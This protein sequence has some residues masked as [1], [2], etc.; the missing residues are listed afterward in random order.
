MLLEKKTSGGNAPEKLG[1][2]LSFASTEAYNLLRANLT[3]SLPETGT[4]HVIG[5][6]SAIPQDGKTYTAINLA[7][8]LANSGKSVLLVDGDMRRPSVANRLGKR[9]SPGLTNFLVGNEKNVMHS[10]VMSANL[11][12]ITAGD[13]PPN[14]SELMGS[15]KMEATLKMLASQFD[16]VLVDLPPVNSV[17]DPIL[18]SKYLEGMILVTRHRHTGKMDVQE[19][20]RALQFAGV[21]ILGFVYN[22]MQ[23]PGGG[24]H[25]YKYSK[26]SKY[27]KYRGGYYNGYYGQPEKPH[28]EEESGQK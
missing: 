20:V 26:Y 19:A 24:Y 10:K 23:R 6:S 9:N 21:H 7:Y 14:P 25:R 1:A 11:S 3:F 8:S 17:A 28:S 27:Y 22:G 2:K 15:E 13:V 4:G 12:V 18:I 16:F 5:I